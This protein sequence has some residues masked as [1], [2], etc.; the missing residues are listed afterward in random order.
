MQSTDNLQ[1]TGSGSIDISLLTPR[2][3]N[4]RGVNTNDVRVAGGVFSCFGVR[5]LLESCCKAAPCLRENGFSVPHAFNQLL[6]DVERFLSL[7]RFDSRE[8]VK[9]LVGKVG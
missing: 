5:P 9:K 1:P 8:K 7:I 6:D 4:P 3:H 2:V